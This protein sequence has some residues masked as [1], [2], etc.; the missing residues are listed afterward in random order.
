MYQLDFPS[1]EAGGVLGAFHTL[2]IGLV[3]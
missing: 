3:V 1:P 2:D